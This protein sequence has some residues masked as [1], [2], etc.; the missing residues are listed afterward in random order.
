LNQ[1]STTGAKTDVLGNIVKGAVTKAV[2]GA[3]K[4]GVRSGIN[5]A[6]GVKTAKTPSI[7]KQLVK[8]VASQIGSK[9]VPKSMAISK[10]IPVSATKKT[11]P[12]KANVSKL[13]PVS[14]ISG[15]ST[16]IK[17]KG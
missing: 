11:A 5:K 3:I 12:L 15:L 14:K 6:L 1:V 16:L 4:G 2:T 13:T 8:G 10:L 7:G 9:V 17:G